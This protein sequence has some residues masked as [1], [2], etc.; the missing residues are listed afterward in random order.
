MTNNESSNSYSSLDIH[1]TPNSENKN[2]ENSQ[3]VISDREEITTKTQKAFQAKSIWPIAILT[4]LAIL[5]GV[6]L[7]AYQSLNQESAVVSQENITPARLPVRVTKVERGLAQQW[8]FDEGIVKSV[9]QRVLNFE[10][11][12]DI[13]FI[14]K[15]DGQ[16]LREGDRVSKGQLLAT[17]DDRKQRAAIETE[18]AN[19]EVSR[20]RLSQSQTELRQSEVEFAKARS[21]LNL[22]ESQLRRREELFKDEVITESELDIYVNSAEQAR[23][24]LKVTNQAIAS[25]QDSVRSAEAEVKASQARLRQSQI[26]LEDTQLVSPIDGIVA[27]INIREGEYW[28]GQ[29]LN[30]SV[31]QEV[32]E[33][34]PMVVVKPQSFEVELELQVDEAKEIRP[35]QKAYVVLEED[36]SAAEATGAT[37]RTLLEI[38]QQKGNQGRVFAVSPTRTPGGR[39]VKVT[40]RD[41]QLLQNLQVGG[42]VYVWI[43]AAANSN[44][45]MVPLGALVPGEQTSSAFVVDEST[46][47]VERRQV[48]RGIEGLTGV[49]IISGI[50][51]GELVVTDG[52]N[53]LVDG[54]LVEIVSREK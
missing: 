52:I 54:T 17:I 29:R 44:A 39:G 22:A 14:A 20:Q 28:S 34:A 7:K 42:R 41:F 8:V 45:V 31:A 18:E 1:P 35:G 43:E 38:A 21:D 13:N 50:E 12:G 2:L 51:P 5:V 19:L 48:E 6:S 40:I 10:A 33:T 53:R 37:N 25:A 49:E 47:K 46:G 15:V 27:Y 32:V 16:D 36:V 4:M 30:S 24:D 23:A 3:T 9:L 11:D 26:D